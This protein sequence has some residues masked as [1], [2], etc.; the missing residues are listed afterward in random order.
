MEAL[1]MAYTF[2]GGSWTELAECWGIEV[3]E[4]TNYMH[5]AGEA[6][7][8]ERGTSPE[9]IV[10]SKT[11]NGMHMTFEVDNYEEVLAEKVKRHIRTNLSY[12]KGGFKDKQ[13]REDI[14]QFLNALINESKKLDYNYPMYEAMLKLE[15]D[16]TLAK[17]VIDNL[18]T[19]WT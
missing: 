6:E 14:H 17:W 2:L 1:E 10:I 8:I 12:G 3:E 18:E 9:T 5:I 13:M 11:I 15:H 16:E 7:P 19:L 4:K